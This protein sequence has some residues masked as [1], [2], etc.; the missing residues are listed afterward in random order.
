[1]REL[2]E[3]LEKATG[4]DIP[5]DVKRAK[6]RKAI[7]AAIFD[8]GSTEGYKG[9]RT[10]TEWQTDAVIRVLSADRA[11]QAERM[12]RLEE[13]LRGDWH[14]V[15]LDGRNEHGSH[16]LNL[17]QRSIE[18]EQNSEGYFLPDEAEAI[19]L[20]AEAKGFR[21]G[22]HGV[23]LVF[24]RCTDE[25]WF[26]HYEFKEVSPELTALLYG[27]PAEQDARALSQEGSDA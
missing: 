2:T 18:L 15:F 16:V 8:P 22:D 4:P 27:T 17:P 12:A 23:V 14:G 6:L 9:E 21:A 7:G 10:L 25:G 13:A 11:A 5:E 26:S 19:L 20:D 24:D 3:R 1:M